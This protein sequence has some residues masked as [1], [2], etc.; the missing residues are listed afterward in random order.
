VTAIK[1]DHRTNNLLEM[2]LKLHPEKARTGED[3]VDLDKIYK[4]GDIVKITRAADDY[5]DEEGNDGDEDEEDLE[6]R[7]PPCDYCYPPEPLENGLACEHPI[8][9]PPA[10]VDGI[11]YMEGVEHHSSCSACMRT[12]P[13]REGMACESCA[14][15]WCGSLFECSRQDVLKKFEGLLSSD[16]DMFPAWKV[17]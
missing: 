5:S 17:Y 1:D 3:K 13:R 7:M 10:P 12:M 15:N 14:Y 4:P 2:Y 6:D 8:P 9:P 11:E 16:S